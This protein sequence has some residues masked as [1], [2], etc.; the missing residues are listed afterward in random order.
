MYK[1]LQKKNSS[2]TPTT[3]QKKS[4][5]PSKLGHFSIQPKP[6]KKSSHPQEIGEYS[7][8]SADRLAANVMRS[9]EAKGDETET[10]TVQPQSES[11]ISVADVVGQRTPTLTPHTLSPL[12]RKLTVGQPGDK[13]E[14][15][16]DTVAAKVVEQ[17]NSPTSQQ[18]VQGKVEP[19][20]QPTVMRDGGV[21]GGA[22][23][24]SVE[25]SI[26]QA[27]GGGQGLSEEVK[28]PMEQAFGADFSGVKVHNNSNADQL[29]RSLNARAFTTGPDI[30]F[31]QGEYNPG[32]RDGQELL[33]H[34]LTHVVQQGQAKPTVQAEGA[35]INDEKKLEQEADVMGAKSLQMQAMTDVDQ[36]LS[37][38]KDIANSNSVIQRATDRDT[39]GEDWLSLTIPDGTYVLEAANIPADGAWS[40]HYRNYL[41]VYATAS[42]YSPRNISGLDANPHNVKNT[43]DGNFQ[44]VPGS[45]QQSTAGQGSAKIQAFRHGY[46]SDKRVMEAYLRFDT[47][48]LI[49]ISGATTLVGSTVFDM[50]RSNHQYFV[51]AQGASASQ[52]LTYSK[53]ITNGYTLGRGAS[54]SN[55]LSSSISSKIGADL[56]IISA[57]I[58]SEIS[59]SQTI[60]NSIQESAS[61]S[62]TES[63]QVS[64]SGSAEGPGKFVIIPTAKVWKTPVTINAFDSTGKRTG[65][66]NDFVYTVIYNQVP[67]VLRVNGETILDSDGRPLPN[68]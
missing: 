2:W 62:M 45:E 67:S 7:R 42:Q 35:S 22:V 43:S 68:Q 65:T 32:S 11:R 5:S 4:K 21:G 17:I 39:D 18:S 52:Q 26:Q 29:N 46:F 3:V 37:L 33:A 9:L 25:Q 49:T 41:G 44:I 51:L 34:E 36:G 60:T 40:L 19:V 8:D 53:S 16:A 66:I 24:D 38:T 48:P 1:P 15:E 12:Q 20:V 14:Q 64:Y 47:V 23:D 56:K 58:G 13:Y 57:E 50:R 54:V 31:K 10:P 55:T 27:Q 61:I 28:E 59:A 63:T 6:N 30:F